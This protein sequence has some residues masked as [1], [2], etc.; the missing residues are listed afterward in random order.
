MNDK[1][2]FGHPR[3][4]FYLAGTEF[5]ERVSFHGMQALLT[6]YMVEQLLLLLRSPT[7]QHVCHGHRFVSLTDP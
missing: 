1:D 5:W 6:L 4:L 7:G 2:I 3:G